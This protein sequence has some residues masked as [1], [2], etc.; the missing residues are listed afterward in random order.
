MKQLSSLAVAFFLTAC[1]PSENEPGT[2][3]NEAATKPAVIAADYLFTNGRI[4]TVNP[5]QEWAEAV[6]VRGSEIVY[7]GNNQGIAAYSGEGSETV[8]L[9][10]RLMLPGFVESHIHLAL[11]GATTSGVILDTTKLLALILAI[12]IH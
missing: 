6:A 7:V 3:A 12:I 4:Y 2:Q 11:G 5:E 1:S 10:G 9:D 8:G